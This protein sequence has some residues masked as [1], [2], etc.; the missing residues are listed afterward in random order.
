MLL[1]FHAIVGWWGRHRV[2][3][4]HHLISAVQLTAESSDVAT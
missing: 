4:V 3:S 2:M 1:A